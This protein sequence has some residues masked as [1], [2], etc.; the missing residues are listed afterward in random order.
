MNGALD[1]WITLTNSI[2]NNCDNI[3]L[4]SYNDKHN[5]LSTNQKCF[6]MNELKIC[7]KISY[8]NSKVERQVS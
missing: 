1:T 3:D 4:N 7:N 5:I 2:K 6:I 8:Y